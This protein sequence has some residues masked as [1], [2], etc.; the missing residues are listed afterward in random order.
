MRWKT[1][2]GAGVMLACASVC[3][4]ERPAVREGVKWIPMPIRSERQAALGMKG[5]E[6]GQCLHGITRAI[7]DDKRIY[8]AID[9]VGVWRSVDGGSSWE[10]CR[11]EGLHCLGTSSVAVHPRKA[12]E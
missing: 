1:R 11:M 8:V 9:V 3:A 2:I 12:D 6:G 5:G 10:M 7:G 4:Q